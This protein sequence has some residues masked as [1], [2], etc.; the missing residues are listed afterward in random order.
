FNDSQSFDG[1]TIVGLI[2]DEP[3][4]HFNWVHGHM[5]LGGLRDLPQLIPHHRI[6]GIVITATLKPEAR[7]SLLELARQHHLHLSEW[8]FENR[9][10]GNGTVYILV[11]RAPVAP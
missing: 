3:S 11:G 8:C 2:D 10:L 7:A 1:R 6:G 4:L 5:V 9:I